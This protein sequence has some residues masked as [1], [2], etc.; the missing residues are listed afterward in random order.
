MEH[1][2]TPR[3]KIEF[4]WGVVPMNLSNEFSWGVI[5]NFAI[6]FFVQDEEKIIFLNNKKKMNEAENFLGS[7]IFYIFL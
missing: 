6:L 7:L 5:L 2:I 3:T 1:I 4:S